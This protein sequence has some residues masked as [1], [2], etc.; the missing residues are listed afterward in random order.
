MAMGKLLVI[1][2]FIVQKLTLLGSLDCFN[3]AVVV[4]LGDATGGL[5]GCNEVHIFYSYSTGDVLGE[6]DNTGGLVG[7][8]RRR[9]LDCYSLSNVNGINNTGGLVG[10]VHGIACTYLLLGVLSCSCFLRG[11]HNVQSY[12]NHVGGG[13]LIIIWLIVLL[14][15]IFYTVCMVLF[16][17][18]LK[19][20]KM[21]R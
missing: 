19:T 12:I 4:G 1:F 13:V 14:S 20:I 9:I 17:K 2:V 6:G 5:V 8:N 18:A 3:E 10:R 16:F 21:V 15:A 11:S 7:Y